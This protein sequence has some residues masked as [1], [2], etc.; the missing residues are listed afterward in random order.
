LATELYREIT[1]I[2]LL[3]AAAW[4]I[5][6]SFLQWLCYF[7]FA[8]GVW[9]IFYYIWLFIRIKWP[10][11][12]MDWDVLFLIPKP[13]YAPVIAAI[14]ISLLGISFSLIVIKI[15][16]INEKIN[17]KIYYWL[18]L[19]FAIIF[20]QISFLNKSV[21]NMSSFPQTYSWYLFFIGIAFSLF[22][23]IMIYYNHFIKKKI[24]R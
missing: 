20:W 1:T 7:V 3:I 5:A 21:P 19:I 23:F 13:W 10:G 12:L 6:R 16:E 15:S 11:S 17:F 24:D 14:I 4:L 18:P 2:I 8:F 9:D 22:A